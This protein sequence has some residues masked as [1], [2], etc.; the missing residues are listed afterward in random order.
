MFEHYV[1]I[2]P[3]TLSLEYQWWNLFTCGNMVLFTSSNCAFY[4]LQMA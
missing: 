1:T 3:E 2:K 4:F